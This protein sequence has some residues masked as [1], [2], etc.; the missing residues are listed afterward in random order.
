MIRTLASGLLCAALAAA[1][2]AAELPFGL[3]PPGECAKVSPLTSLVQPVVVYGTP[4][5]VYPQLHV[6]PTD[7]AAGP[8][9]GPLADAP[10][11]L[12]F[13]GLDPCDNPGS[14]CRGNIIVPPPPPRPAAS[15]RRVVRESPAQPG[16]PPGVP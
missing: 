2:A 12:H 6:S 11:G 15:A 3:A 14:G 9:S 7:V 8:A 10:S 16:N 13:P 5:R 4:W 1:P